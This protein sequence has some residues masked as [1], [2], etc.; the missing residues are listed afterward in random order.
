MH[1]F[2]VLFGLPVQLTP[3]VFAYSLLYPYTDNFLD[4]PAISPRE[5]MEFNQRFYRRLQ[6][7]EVQPISFREKQICQ[8]VDMIES[9]FDRSSYPQVFDSLLAIHSAQTRSLSQQ[10][11]QPADS[12]DVLQISIEK[13]GT[14][15]L[16]DG[17]LVA[18]SLNEDQA[19]FLFGY[20]AFTQL[21]DD[22]EDVVQDLE[23]GS[24]TLI[25]Q[26]AQRSRLDP[27]T[28]QT[29]HFGAKVFDL[30]SVFPGEDARI[31]QQILMRTIN[32]LLIAS[33]ARTHTLYTPYY[34]HKLQ[35][36]LPFRFAGLE[37]IQKRMIALNLSPEDWLQLLC[38]NHE[39]II[40][41][42]PLT[43]VLV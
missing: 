4:D 30:M 22:L 5:K 28:S 43:F 41:L 39:T 23:C 38:E 32:P 40:E 8:L 29:I 36:G 12:P 24:L 16:A 26:C 13:G 11:T 25:T 18:G 1:F 34:L 7:F 35:C 3:A 19:R 14:S 15:V 20:G 21:M 9:Q 42:N 37:A 10:H 2:Q 27:V 33:A 6:G 17:F 31:L